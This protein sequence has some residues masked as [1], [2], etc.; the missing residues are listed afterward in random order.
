MPA[1]ITRRRALQLGA[2]G[3]LGHLFTADAGRRF[4]RS[5]QADDRLRR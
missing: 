5:V 3:T 1:R 2:A 4:I